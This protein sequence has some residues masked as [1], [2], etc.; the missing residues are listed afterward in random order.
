MDEPG[1]RIF[2]LRLSESSE[3]FSEASES[4]VLSNYSCDDTN[5]QCA[6]HQMKLVFFREAGIYHKHKYSC[7]VLLLQVLQR[8]GISNVDLRDDARRPNG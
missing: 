5:I 4:D 7:F 8:M 1:N 3:G 2:H 6:V